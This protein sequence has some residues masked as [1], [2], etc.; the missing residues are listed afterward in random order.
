MN[1]ICEETRKESFIKIEASEREQQVLEILKD[2]Y[3]RTAREVAEEM[4]IK[5]YTNTTDRN[6]ASPR[7]HN[8]LA[9][10]KVIIVGLALDHV[11]NR[12]VSIY[13]IAEA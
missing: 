6:N 3:E 7:L 1:K 10:R 12:N 5:G 11:T 2:G 4:F 13:R 8:L 9:K